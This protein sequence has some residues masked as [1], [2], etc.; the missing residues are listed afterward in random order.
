MSLDFFRIERG[1]ELDDSVLYLQGLGAP[2]TSAD[3][4]AA[5][6]GSVYTDNSTGALYTKIATGSGADKWQKMA[7]EQYVNNAVG[8]TI[9]WREPAKV[10]DNVATTVP[11]G[12]AT[13]PIVVDGVSITDGQRVLFSAIVGGN[14]KN[15]YV[16]EQATG[17]FVEDTNAETNGDAVYVEGGTSAGRTYV[18]NGTN[19]VLT[20]Q[21]SDDELG[22]LRAFVGKGASGSEM[23]AFASNNFVADSTSLETAISTLDAA[24]GANVAL[25]NFIDPADSINANIQSLDAEIGANV[26]LGAWVTPANTI[27]Q[28]L[29]ALDTHLGVAFLAGNYITAGQQVSGAVTALDNA[30]GPNVADGFTILGANKVQ[31]NIQ[32]LDTQIG[33]VLTTSDYFTAGTSTNTAVQQL[34]AAVQEN[35]KEVTVTNVTSIQTVDAIAGAKTAKWLVRVELASDPSRVYSTEV[36]ALTDGTTSDYT[37]YG[38]LRIGTAIPGLA[39]T[40]DLNAGELR[41]RVAATGAVNVT[42]H[43]VAAVV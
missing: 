14:G 11:T 43:R 27:N 34:A 36:F 39:V 31:Q 9:S 13:Q 38:T 15:V 24:L 21:A 18:F 23:P 32:A 35:N 29:Q 28:N 30:I 8:A 20:D 12:T 37:R 33:P 22:Y 4:I 3:T 17:T 25:G 42:S 26:N 10:R 41:L 1:L 40:V 2:G 7:S 19:W 5:L 16:Y 6:I